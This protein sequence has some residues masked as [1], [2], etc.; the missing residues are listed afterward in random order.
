M[1]SIQHS[2]YTFRSCFSDNNQPASVASIVSLTYKAKEKAAAA[3]AA[4]ALKMAKLSAKLPL[5]KA[6]PVVHTT[7]S[8]ECKARHGGMCTLAA[9]A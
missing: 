6:H 8:S 4:R 7:R 3:A 1:K 5:L 2:S 9:T